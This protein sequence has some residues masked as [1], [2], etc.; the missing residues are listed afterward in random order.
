M[1]DRVQDEQLNK[2]TLQGLSQVLDALPDQLMRA[3]QQSRRTCLLCIQ[4]NPR[5]EQCE[6][7][8]PPLR[9]PARVIA[10][11]CASF[12]HDDIPF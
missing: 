9:P 4:F 11:G 1:S 6:A 3:V 7:A 2:A 8:R 12:Q 10:F 5:T